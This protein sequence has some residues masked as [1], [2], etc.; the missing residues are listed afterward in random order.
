MMIACAAMAG[1][2]TGA[3][4]VRASASTAHAGK[5]IVADGDKDKSKHDCKGKN[6]CKGKGGCKSSD[7][8]CKGKNDCSGKGGCSTAKDEPKPST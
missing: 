3:L 8:G 1:L 5:M 4:A 6:D 2:Y 7:N